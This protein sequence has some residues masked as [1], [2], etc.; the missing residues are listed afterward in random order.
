MRSGIHFSASFRIYLYFHFLMKPRGIKLLL[1]LCCIAGA[2]QAQFAKQLMDK[3]WAELLVDNDTSAL[4]LYEQAREE[5]IKENN[6]LLA[7]EAQLHLGISSYG[8][9]MY[10]G[11]KYATEALQ[12]YDAL[13]VNHK[14][15]A[16]I[17]R[18]KCL[19]LIATIKA[20]QQKYSEA[21]FL[22]YEALKIASE[23]KD[24]SSTKGI[25]QFLLGSIYKKE[26]RSDSSA[27]FFY[28][29]L[30]SRLKNREAAYLPTS[31]VAVG[32]IEQGKGNKSA[33]FANFQKAL[34]IADSTGNRQAQISVLLAMA[35]WYN[36]AMSYT[37]SE[38]LLK[39]ARTLAEN[40]S[41]KTYLI[42]VLRKLKEFY[43]EQH[44]LDKALELDDL[45]A[46]TIESSSTIEKE[47]LTKSLEVQFKLSEKEKELSLLK[48]E[49]A[50]SELTN[51][52]LYGTILV[53][54]VIALGSILFLR[55]LHDRNKQLLKNK[56][57]LLHVR[58]QQK[59][60]REQQLKNEIEFKESQLSAITIQMMQ[61]N[62]LLQ[63]LKAKLE[64]ADGE[65][66]QESLNKI[67][68]KG[69]N[70]DKEWK[71]FNTHF[72]AVNKNF[73]E[74]VKQNF[75]DISPNELKI[76][77]LIKMNLSSKEMANILNIS[78]DSVKTARYRL[79][80]KL[81]LSTEDNLTEFIMSL[82]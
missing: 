1:V 47:H 35:A 80:K 51:Y 4:R 9:S 76:C 16:V 53:I 56:E 44:Q 32:E 68:S 3:A 2:L 30:A 11:M 55:R 25:A 36:T 42:K 38:T 71:D 57:E 72:E 5:A 23:F 18:G 63:E 70:Q 37:E 62:E 39:K 58:E 81:N 64:N 77:A 29:A 48:K 22:G 24:T 10:N 14:N 54:I 46:G 20:R 82:H 61:K 73:Y 52:L 49:A 45:I 26:Q 7:A 41:D 34:L 66:A 33:A 6:Q 31:Y 19:L 12:A 59:K 40:I 74:K 69:L 17:G 65:D 15:A 79:R 8:S 27:Y 50:I 43:K 75:P 28:A 78:P 67:I 21:K 13:A 60:Q